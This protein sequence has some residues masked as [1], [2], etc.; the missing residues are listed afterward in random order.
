MKGQAR[1]KC[2][3]GGIVVLG[4]GWR[5]ER[6]GN[7]WMTLNIFTV[8]QAVFCAVE[9][10]GNLEVFSSIGLAVGNEINPSSYVVACA[11]VVFRQNI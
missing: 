1:I 3:G 4:G 8:K 2:A 10:D 7:I 5:R 11:Y 9:P 6:G